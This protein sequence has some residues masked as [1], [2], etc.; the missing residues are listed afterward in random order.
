[1]VNL[2]VDKKIASR[3]QP[4][5]HSLVFAAH[6][7]SAKQGAAGLAQ[8]YSLKKRRKGEKGLTRLGRI[9]IIRV[10]CC[11]GKQAKRE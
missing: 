6:K 4:F 10:L 7:N 11:T 9:S 8:S 2:L 3:A 5:Q 1:M